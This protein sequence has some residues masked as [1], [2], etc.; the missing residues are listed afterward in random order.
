MKKYLVL[1]LLLC[2]C[3][4]EL[5]TNQESNYSAYIWYKTPEEVYATATKS[6]GISISNREKEEYFKRLAI[7]YGGAD[8]DGKILIGD[9]PDVLYTLAVARVAWWLAGKLL[10]KENSDPN[11]PMP[12]G[13]DKDLPVQ[14]LFAGGEKD[15]AGCF[16][17]DKQLWCDFDDELTP[18]T[19]TQADAEKLK[20]SHAD[21]KKIMHNMQDMGDFVG[22]VI[23]N[24]TKIKGYDHLPHY[25]LD[26]V[27]IPHLNEE[28]DRL[29]WRM[30]VFSILL[31]GPFF[32]N[33]DQQE[34]K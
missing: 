2:A 1:I 13:L 17:D 15:Q 21:R 30:V 5:L 28:G 24:L 3:K 22:V 25:L 11:M 29:A 18:N 12:A 33:F 6:W 10:F 9:A 14:E 32:M 16:A 26:E 7:S 8:H 31:R 23:D 27:F 20:T 4:Q 19:Y 34:R